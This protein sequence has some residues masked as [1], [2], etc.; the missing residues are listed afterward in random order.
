MAVYTKVENK[1]VEEFLN[2]YDLGSL[3]SLEAIEEG[4]SNTNYHLYTDKG[5]YILTLFEER[6]DKDF[7]PF[8]FSFKN[9]LSK[10]GLAC[11]KG[12]ESKNGKI[13]LNLCSKNAAIS[14]FLPGSSV[15]EGHITKEHCVSLGKTVARMHKAANDFSMHRENDLD[16]KGW[17]ALLSKVMHQAKHVEEGLAWLI[18]EELTFLEENWPKDLP[19]AVVHTDLFP[20]NVFF[21]DNEVSGVIDFY[22]SCNDFLAYDLAL[23]I[24]AWCFDQDNQFLPERFKALLNGYQ[25]ERK[26]EK[27]EKD[28]LSILCRGAAVRILMTRLYDWLTHNPEDFVKPKDPKEYVEKLKYHQNAK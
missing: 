12:I 11:P 27:A 9:H 18:A 22:F 4:V 16:L 1:Q 6:T 2:N 26:L 21:Q 15:D 5:R 19:K 20:D 7:L 24:N 14:S 23:V 13:I 25:S 3:V 10:E 8:F 17:K 28:S